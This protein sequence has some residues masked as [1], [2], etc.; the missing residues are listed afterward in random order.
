MSFQVDHRDDVIK[1]PNA[2][3]RFYPS[4]KQVCLEDIPILEGQSKA[5]PSND[6]DE[7][8]QSEKSLS[9]QDRTQRRKDRNRRHVWVAEG[10]LLR[11]I[12]VTTGLSDSQFTEMVSGSLK[13]SDA[14]VTGIQAT[15]V[16]PARN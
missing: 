1:I 14:L 15:P 10:D 5:N 11:A 7:A 13:K 16:G 4:A 6:Q 12:E 9:A 3:L 8:Q 2:A